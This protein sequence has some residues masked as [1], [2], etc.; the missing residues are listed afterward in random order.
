MWQGVV[1]A[2]SLTDLSLFQMV[3]IVGTSVS[4]LENED[5]TLTFHKIEVSDESKDNYIQSAT[6]SLKPSFYTHLCKEGTMIVVFPNKIFSFKENDPNL[7]KAR[8]Y[9]LSI[10]IIAKQMPFEHLITHPFD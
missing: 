6:I 2:E 7:A 1:I 10:G 8:E 5:R 9:G 3:K 4:K